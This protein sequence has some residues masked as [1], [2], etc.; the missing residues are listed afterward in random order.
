MVAKEILLINPILFPNPEDVNYTRRELER[1][2][3]I[4][5]KRG[6]AFFPRLQAAILKCSESNIQNFN[7]AIETAD[8]D[9]R[10]TLAQAGF[11]MDIQKHLGW[12]ENQ[13]EHK[14]N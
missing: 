2:G 7:E 1:L 12:I 11:S 6:E 4:L 9:W 8:I 3:K 14:D 5:R 10:D 13:K